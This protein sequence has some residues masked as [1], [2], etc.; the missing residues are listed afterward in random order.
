[1]GLIKKI[2]YL[3]LIIFPVQEIFAETWFSKNKT[4]SVR[5]LSEV[6]NLIF[7]KGTGKW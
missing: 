4:Y 6:K 7:L 2:L 1:M 5:L 3:I